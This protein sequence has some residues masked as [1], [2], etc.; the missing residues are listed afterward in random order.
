MELH[1]IRHGQTNW[2]EER[3]AQGQSDSV[4]TELGI[5]Q[6]KALGIRI[7]A[8]PFDALYC[9]SSKR[10]KQTAAHAFPDWE[11]PVTY[12]DSLREIQMGEWEGR[13][14]AELE[15]ESPE[16]FQHFWHEPHKFDVPGAET[17]FQLQS[18]ALATIRDIYIH[19]AG[20]LVALVSHGALIKT[21]LAHIEGR[22][23]AQLWTPPQMHNC[24]H[25]IVRVDAEDDY[26]IIQYADQPYDQL[27]DLIQGPADARSTS[28][29]P[30]GRS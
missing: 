10:T 20:Q 21:V 26:R 30:N 5:E 13:L 4:L 14:Y 3:R 11:K 7:S 25:S 15:S 9:S 27:R 19:H 6:A 23:L 28:E 17:F 8:V 22:H 18:R 16:S 12:L 2:N 24:A 1:L 29:T